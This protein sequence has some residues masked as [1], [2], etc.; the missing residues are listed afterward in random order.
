M[1]SGLFRA[2]AESPARSSPRA[3]PKSK[4]AAA[5]SLDAAAA[6]FH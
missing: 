1:V 6:G 5:A 4:P 2:L 3:V